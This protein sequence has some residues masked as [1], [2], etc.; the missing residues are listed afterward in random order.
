MFVIY[1]SGI[2]GCGKTTQAKLL[3]EFLINENYDSQYQ[4]LRWS[5]SIIRIISTAKSLLS[6]AISDKTKNKKT[7]TVTHSD[8]TL[9]QSENLH[10][11]KWTL[12]KKKLF[13]M[14]LFSFLWDSYSLRDY[15]R[16]YQQSSNNWTSEI[17]ILD[18]YLMDFFV[19]QS[20]NYNES[21]NNYKSRLNENI[22]NRFKKPDLFFLIDISPET[23][24]ERKRDGTSMKHLNILANVYNEIKTEDGIFT[25]QGQ[26]SKEA[27][28]EEIKRIVVKEL[29]KRN[30]F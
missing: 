7:K 18:R 5:P 2:D 1:I 26:Q 19:D 13:S 24:W 3:N 28:H 16:S 22:L 9:K 4:W 29:R 27:I 23:G 25:I 11:S 15:Y 12:L 8:E 14:R 30:E 21:V 6:F 20:I 17:I 10:F